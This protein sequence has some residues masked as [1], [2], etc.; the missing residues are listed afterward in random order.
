MLEFL[1]HIIRQAGQICTNKQSTLSLEDVEFKSKKDLVTTIDKKVEDYLIKQINNKYPSHGIWGEETG[2]QMIDSD[3][4]WIIDPIDG[5]TSFLHQQAYYSVSIAVRKHNKTIMSAVYAPA[6]DDLF[7]A[8]QT[9]GVFLNNDPVTVSSTTQLLHSVMATGFACMRSNLSDN[10]LKY[11]NQIL[12]DI[13]DIRRYGSAALDLCYVG[14]GKIDG[15]WEMNLNPYDI[16]AG[17][18]IVEQAGGIVTDFNGNK[19]YPENGII[20]SN[21]NLHSDLMKYFI[22]PKVE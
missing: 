6:F 3:Y 22:D 16:A 14:C 4:Q 11:F 10:N 17:A 12:P 2:N 1:L 13:R 8:E 20:A 21:K 18:F 19:N 5:T 15:F 9:S 7:Y